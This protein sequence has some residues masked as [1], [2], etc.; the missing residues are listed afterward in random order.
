[1]G[2]LF[3][4]VWVLCVLAFLAGAAATWLA[5]VRPRRVDVPAD[6][7]TWTPVP[8]WASRR[9]AAIP[10][11]AEPTTPISPAVSS[12]V[13]PALAAL[14]ARDPEGTSAGPAITAIGELDRLGVAGT[15]P[16]RIGIPTQATPVDS[17]DPG[18]R[19]DRWQ[20]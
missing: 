7:P 13:D 3:V 8:A 12:P 17:P 9:T 11:L 2:W 1:M 15:V 19:T 14:D 5:F 10:T 18:T 4:Q 6:G 16:P 20:S